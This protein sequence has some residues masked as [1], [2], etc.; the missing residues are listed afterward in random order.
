[1]WEQMRMNISDART[2]TQQTTW[3]EF[4]PWIFKIISFT[5]V[6]ACVFPPT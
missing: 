1:M 2:R 6:G 3:E 4:Y 5:T